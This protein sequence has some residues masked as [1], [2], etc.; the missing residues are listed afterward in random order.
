M[1]QSDTTIPWIEKYRPSNFDDIVLDEINKKLFKN[2]LSKK[3]FP[4]LLF[5]GPPGT[6]KT[7]TIINIINSFQKNS[8]HDIQGSIIHLNASD[9]RGIDVIRNHIQQFVKSKNIFK[10]GLKFVILDEVDYM[11]KNAQ[12][13]LK[14][15]IQSYTTNVRFCLVCNYISKIDYSLQNEFICA[16]FN[17]LPKNEIYKLIKTIIVKENLY[18]KDNT[19]NT[20]MHNYNSDIRSMINYI[21]LNQNIIEWND[22]IITDIVWSKINEILKNK[23]NPETRIVEF[24]DYIHEV[25]IKYNTDKKCILKDYFNY[26][27]R[28][29]IENVTSDFLDMIEI[30]MHSKENHINN[31]I[32]YI[33]QNIKL[34]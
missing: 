32:D 19:I 22:N 30:V 25:S 15:L 29:H 14:Y 24:K 1:E 12:N 26:L 21:Q 17:Q 20:I 3:Y 23:N 13:A 31:V 28:F 11:T 34:K 7:T 27:I 8:G 2:V 33:G 16:R 6:G 9:E 4:N 5:Y 10:T 18:L